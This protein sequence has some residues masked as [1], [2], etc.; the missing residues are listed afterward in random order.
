MVLLVADRGGSSQLDDWLAPLAE[1]YADVLHIQGIAD[2]SAVPRL[3][4]PGVRALFRK[5]EAVP[6]WMDWTG[7]VA[8]RF[9]A[10]A[11]VANVYLI[12]PSGEVLH[13]VSGAFTTSDWQTLRDAIDASTRHPAQSA[14]DR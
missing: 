5:N 8:E 12:A 2:L 6:I 10:Q 13:R 1:G 11:E 4:R 7:E 3:L 14:P 9:G